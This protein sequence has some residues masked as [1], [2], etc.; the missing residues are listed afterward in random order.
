VL[1]RMHARYSLIREK[2]SDGASPVSAMVV[3]PLIDLPTPVSTITGTPVF[4]EE[5]LVDK[6][7]RLRIKKK[8]LQKLLSEYQTEFVKINGRPVK[9]SAD[10]EEVRDEYE[11]Y[12]EVKNEIAKM[13]KDS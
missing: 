5:A 1:K 4:S 10:R 8:S 12:K 13:D 11:E 6:L 9:S 7:A 3:T 2:L